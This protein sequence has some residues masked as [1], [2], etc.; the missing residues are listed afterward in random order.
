MKNFLLFIKAGW[1]AVG[2]FYMVIE[3]VIKLLARFT[4][5]SYLYFSFYLFHVSMDR[6]TEWI[7]G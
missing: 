3:L 1:L 4:L 5:L 2:V 6:W 7:V